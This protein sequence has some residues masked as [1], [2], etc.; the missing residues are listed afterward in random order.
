MVL[1]LTENTIEELASKISNRT[2]RDIVDS[3]VNLTRVIHNFEKFI[4]PFITNLEDYK[5]KLK[6]QSVRHATEM[7]AKTSENTVL[8]EV[9]QHLQNNRLF[10][11]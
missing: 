4:E 11:I 2:R 10:L 5:T 3:L 9:N 7:A 1:F 6:E 8:R